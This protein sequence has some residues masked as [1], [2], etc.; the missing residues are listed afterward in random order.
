VLASRSIAGTKFV[1][2]EKS[3]QKSGAISMRYHSGPND[4]LA[5]RLPAQ[6][7]AIRPS[8]FIAGRH[9]STYGYYRRLDRKKAT[10]IGH[11]LSLIENRRPINGKS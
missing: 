7:N 1:G 4:I 2:I 9:A 6:Q 8:H 5:F 11:S 10:W 3:T